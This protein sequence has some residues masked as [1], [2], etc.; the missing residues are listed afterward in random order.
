MGFSSLIRRLKGQIFPNQ[1]SVLLAYLL[2]IFPQL[3]QQPDNDP[4][5]S[6]LL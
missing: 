2:P 6:Q 5:H 3:S 1:N 4:Y